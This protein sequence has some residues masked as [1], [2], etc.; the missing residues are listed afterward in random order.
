MLRTHTCGELRIEHD[1]RE[2]TICGWVDT[3]R[4]FGG[5]Q[6]IDLR[7]RYGKTQV[8]FTPEVWGCL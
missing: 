5:S 7:D 2:V 8:I 4:D 3:N 1:G 6:F